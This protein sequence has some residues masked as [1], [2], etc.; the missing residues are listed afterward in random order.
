MQG[1]LSDG[2]IVNGVGGA[3]AG[4]DKH[5]P[6]EDASNPRSQ[7]FAGYERFVDAAVVADFLSIRR[8]EVLKLSREGAIRGYPYRGQQRHTYRY[9]LSEVSA[10]FAALLNARRSTIT[11]AAPVSLRKK[12]ND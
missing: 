2:N 10:D 6:V 1:E 9:R 8:D 3:G 5:R 7:T 4:A 11:A 12:S